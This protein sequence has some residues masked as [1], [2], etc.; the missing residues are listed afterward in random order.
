MESAIFDDT[1]GYNRIIVILKARGGAIRRPVGALF[2]ECLP[3]R[4]FC[5]FVAILWCFFDPRGSHFE[6]LG[7]TLRHNFEGF[8]ARKPIPKGPQKVEVG[9]RADPPY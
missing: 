6:A 5:D 9:G 7:H 4:T 3:E 2:L 1:T 8:L